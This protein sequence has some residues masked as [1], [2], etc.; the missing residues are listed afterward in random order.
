MA[1]GSRPPVR[2]RKD[3]WR[4]KKRRGKGERS[5]PAVT[6]PDPHSTCS[7]LKKE[8]ERQKRYE[9]LRANNLTVPFG[10]FVWL[11]KARI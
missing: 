5:G 1:R 3:R 2:Y 10:E 7:A 8:E 11:R 9:A 6:P 4:E